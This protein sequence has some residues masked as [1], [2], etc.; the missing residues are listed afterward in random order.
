[1]KHSFLKGSLCALIIAF[2]LT[3]T[4]TAQ[5]KSDEARRI[6]RIES[7]LMTAVVIKG[8]PVLRMT[9]QSRMRYYHVPA[10]SMAFFDASGIRWVRAYGATSTTLFQAGSISK[11]VSSVGLMRAVQ[12][13][14]LKL[15]E[16]VN[17]VLRGWKVPDNALTAKQ[18]VTLRELLSMT[19]GTTVHGFDGY[20]RGKPIPTRRKCSMGGRR[21]IRHRSASICSPARSTVTPAA[22]RLSRSCYYFRLYVRALQRTCTIKC[23]RLWA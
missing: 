18:P 16:N 13:G 3:F 11:P 9:L 10:M 4:S 19:A 23:W 12:D 15:D 20:K 17:N 1:M 5:P 2:A 6:A 22:D 14:L 21:Q 7:S 8:R